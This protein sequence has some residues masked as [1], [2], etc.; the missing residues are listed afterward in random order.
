MSVGIK[1]GYILKSTKWK[2]PFLV[3]MVQA[4]GDT[5]MVAGHYLLR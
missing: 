3:R 2:E 4:Q 1:P 5:M